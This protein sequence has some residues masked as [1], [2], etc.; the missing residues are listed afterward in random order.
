MS[1][2]QQG[3]MACV[4]GRSWFLSLIVHSSECFSLLQSSPCHLLKAT[5]E[6]AW[7]SWRSLPDLPRFHFTVSV[8]FHCPGLPCSFSFLWTNLPPISNYDSSVSI[9]TLSCLPPSSSTHILE[10]NMAM[11]FYRRGNLGVVGSPASSAWLWGCVWFHFL[12]Q[13]YLLK[14]L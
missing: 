12:R 13:T 1:F 8:H 14:L 9:H 7:A 3:C 6:Y 11:I 2:T 4:G 10:G 5:S